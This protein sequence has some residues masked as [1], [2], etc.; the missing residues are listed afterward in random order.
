[1]KT[2]RNFAIDPTGAYLLAANQNSN[3]IVSL[4][5]DPQTGKLT[6]TGFTTEVP[7]PV[8][9]KFYPSIWE[10]DEQKQRESSLR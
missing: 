7:N 8:C 6:P 1:G 5:I 9:L 4:R 10:L 3:S 2:P